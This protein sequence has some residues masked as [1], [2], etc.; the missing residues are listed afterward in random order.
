MQIPSRFRKLVCNTSDVKERKRQ[1]ARDEPSL[2]RRLDSS[3]RRLLLDELLS[4]PRASKG[5]S[6]LLLCLYMAE[7]RPSCRIPRSGLLGS[8]SKALARAE[9]AE[10]AAKE[11]STRTALELLS[12]YEG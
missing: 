10:L 3:Q 8:D 11:P 7:T 12:F 2:A 1:S 5:A 6:Q 9:L 4:L